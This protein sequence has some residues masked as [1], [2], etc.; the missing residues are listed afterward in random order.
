M[1]IELKKNNN[2]KEKSGKKERENNKKTIF[3]KENSKPCEGRI[4]SS[5]HQNLK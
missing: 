5:Y 2:S 4:E 3:D 1:S